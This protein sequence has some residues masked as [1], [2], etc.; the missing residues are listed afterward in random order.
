MRPYRSIAMLTKVTACGLEPMPSQEST[1]QTSY[2]SLNTNLVQ[3]KQM[4][5][6]LKQT[7]L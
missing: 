6:L 2:C 5:M 7:T 1:Y 4:I 3:K